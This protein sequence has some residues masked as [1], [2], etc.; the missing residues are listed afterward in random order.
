[1]KWGWSEMTEGLLDW[2]VVQVQVVI[3]RIEMVKGPEEKKQKKIMER[4]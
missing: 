1:M 2:I 4:S 3:D